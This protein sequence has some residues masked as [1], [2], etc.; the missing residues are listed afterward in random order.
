MKTTMMRSC[1]LSGPMRGRDD[2]HFPIFFAATRRLQDANWMVFNPAKIDVVTDGWPSQAALEGTPEQHRLGLRTDVNP[3]PSSD[4]GA[5][6]P[7]SDIDA[8]LC[9]QYAQ[10]DCKIILEWL[11]AERGDALVYLPGWEGSAG[12]RAEVALA[13]WVMLPCLSL[14]EALR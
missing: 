7:S 10:R 14:E 12:A 9:R 8:A 2:Y 13:E 1:Y 3:L 5:P 11:K 4:I 6:L